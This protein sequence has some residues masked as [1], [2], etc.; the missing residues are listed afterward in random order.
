MALVFLWHLKVLYISVKFH[1]IIPNGFQVTKGTQ[2]CDGQA[3]G[4]GDIV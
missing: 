4:L 3:T 1:A 2:L